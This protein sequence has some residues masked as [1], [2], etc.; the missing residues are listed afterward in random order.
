M[1]AGQVA[2]GHRDHLGAGK[3]LA[4]QDP[5]RP[6]S[7]ADEPEP[8][9]IIGPGPAWGR[10]GRHRRRGWGRRSR[11][12][13][14]RGRAAEPLATIHGSPLLDEVMRRNPEKRAGQGRRRGR[15]ETSVV[16][17]PLGISSRWPAWSISKKSPAG[18]HRAPRGHLGGTSPARH[19][20]ELSLPEFS[21]TMALGSSTPPRCSEPL[22]V[23]GK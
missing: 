9:P 3:C 10:R 23:P 5:P 2:I 4:G 11:R 1:A 12:G 16:V 15:G 13:R 22:P 20:P 7:Q 21:S 18:A 14:S 8:D 6:A 17:W 19:E